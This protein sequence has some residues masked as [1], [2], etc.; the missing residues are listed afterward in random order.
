MNKIVF[1]VIAL[2][3]IFAAP[4]WAGEV[5]EEKVPAI[6]DVLPE[7][8]IMFA[9][10]SPWANWSRD[11]SRTALAKVAAEPEVRTF[12]SGPFM[13]VSQLIKRATDAVPAPGQ[14]VAEPKLGPKPNDPQTMLTDFFR[15][16][17]DIARGPFSVGVRYSAEDAQAKRIPAVVMLLGIGDR[18]DMEATNNLLAGVVDE[19]LKKWKV[20]AVSI[21]DYQ[22]NKLIS[23]TS[24]DKGQ[25]RNLL[26]VA[27]YKGRLI[28]SNEVKICTQVMDGLSGTL[29][30]KLSDSE[31]YKATGLAGG[32]HLVAYLDVA[33]LQK[34]L[35]AA[36]KPLADTPNQ[37]DDFFVLAGLNKTIAVAWSLRMSGAAFE[38]RTAIFSKEE[39]GGLLGTLSEEALSPD[40]LKLCPA[41]TPLAAGFRLKPE[42]IMPFIRNA[43]KALQGAKGMENFTA[44]EKQLNTE[45]GRDLE[46]DMRAA[47]GNELIITSLAGMENTG[48]VGAVSAFTA[49]LS[50]QDM[51]KADDLLVQVLT[52]VAA[53]N[54][55]AGN[56]ANVL[57]EIEHD[58]AKIRYLLTPVAGG[59]IKFSPSFVLLNN[60]LVMAL[61]VPT[62]KRS[63]RVLKDGATLADSPAF[64]TALNEV[65]GKMGPTFTYVDWGFLYKAVFNISTDAIKLVAPTDVLR[66]IGLD[67]NL[68][69]ST[70]TVS[71]HLF[72]GLSVA[73]ITPNGIT[74]TS[75]SPLPSIEVLTPPMGAI[76]AVFATFRPLFATPAE[77]VK[78]AEK[79]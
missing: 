22:N 4:A 70:E 77:P 23:I 5:R 10:I 49:S 34:A 42:K 72:P 16:M 2:I 69:P 14:P 53:R 62:L 66:E 52:R 41:G 50:V 45:L 68:L 33:S 8:T 29:A 7:G 57:K 60:R 43:V 71:Q 20:D 38:S 58:G 25:R 39:R 78:P 79:K 11:F 37:L 1:Q 19:L 36:E 15:V 48:P 6:A 75:R 55:P 28:A 3:A 24:D 13:Q 64:K 12:F 26:T 30:R 74:M 21:T 65:G 44:I 35:G 76:T 51:K 46:K 56:G 47:F 32:E 73:H 17:S 59:L 54:D 27:I 63:M 61:D 40:A 18:R 9:E 67:M 31:S